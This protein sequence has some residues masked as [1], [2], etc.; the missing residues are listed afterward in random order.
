MGRWRKKVMAREEWFK[1]Q[2]DGSSAA[3]VGGKRKK[4]FQQDGKMETAQS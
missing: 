1:D 3:R 2:G 4:A